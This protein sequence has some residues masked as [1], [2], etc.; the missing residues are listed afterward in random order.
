[1]GLVTVVA[2]VLTQFHGCSYQNCFTTSTYTCINTSRVLVVVKCGE[3]L[4]ICTVKQRTMQNLPEQV[5]R[6]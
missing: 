6:V 5:F 1:M 2:L 3:Q 4:Q